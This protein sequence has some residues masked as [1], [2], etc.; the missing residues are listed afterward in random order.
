MSEYGEMTMSATSNLISPR[1]TAS[2]SSPDARKRSRRTSDSKTPKSTLTT[3]FD[4]VIPRRESFSQTGSPAVA[5]ENVWN[6][7]ST[8]ARD[9]RLLFKRRITTLYNTAVGLR[10]YAELNY[11][12]FRKILKKWVVGGYSTD[13]T[14]SSLDMTRFLIVR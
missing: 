12:G 5:N 1:M 7:S 10:S 6:S 13:R 9:T 4:K 3:L 11:S 14:H 2:G 8:H